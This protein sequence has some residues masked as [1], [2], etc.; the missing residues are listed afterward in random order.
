[1]D[2]C[3]QHTHINADRSQYCN[4]DANRDANSDVNRDANGNANHSCGRGCSPH[5]ICHA[6]LDRNGANHRI[7]GPTVNPRTDR[8]RNTITVTNRHL[9]TATNGNAQPDRHGV[10]PGAGRGGGLST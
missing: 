2:G 4:R 7:T 10:A 8:Q 5:T 3:R 6:D 1:M 9:H